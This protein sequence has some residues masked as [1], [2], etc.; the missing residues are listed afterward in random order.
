MNAAGVVTLVTLAIAGVFA[1]DLMMPLGVAVWLLYIPPLLLCLWKLR[2]A[3]TFAFTGVCTA[4]ILVAFANI[5]ETVNDPHLALLN[6]VLAIGMLWLTVFLGLRYRRAT[7]KIATLAADLASRARELETAN[8][9]LE[10]FSYTVS[11]D[12]RKP[13]SAVIGYSEMLQELC[14]ANLDEEC[15]EYLRT[16]L[17]SSLRMDELID[18]LL[19][20]SLVND[21]ALT[22]EPVDLSALAR[23]IADRLRQG[24]PQRM[25]TMVI[26]DGLVADADRHLMRVVLENLLDNAWKYTSQKSAATIEFGVAVLKE[27]PAYFVKDNGVGFNIQQ[28]GKLFDAF[29]RLHGEYQG[30]GIGLATVKRIIDRHGGKIWAEGMEGEGATFFFSL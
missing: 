26:A 22:R 12:L 4:L 11:H 1:T 23:E 29:Q 25:V 15:K 6:R 7:E 24:Q 20:F 9:E 18:T 3:A 27:G 19:K 8:R 17:D 14:T 13:L 2:P 5:T 21:Y 30:L 28:A 10:A 16:I